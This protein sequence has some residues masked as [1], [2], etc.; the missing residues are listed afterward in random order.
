MS[1]NFDIPLNRRGTD[2]VKWDLKPKTSDGRDILPMWVADMDFAIPE[3]VSEA[4]LQRVNHPVFG[5][6]YVSDTL[7]QAFVAWQQQRN[8][9]VV[10][11]ESLVYAPGVMPAVRAA[12]L[13]I[14]E[15]GDEVI[16]QPPVYYP[17]FDAIRENGRVMVENPLVRVGDMFEMD[18]A[19]LRAQVTSRT[20][21]LLL[22]SPHNPVGRVWSRA[23]LVAL[24]EICAR[25]GITI[26]CDEIHADLIRDGYS[27][28]PL[29]SISPE[30]AGMT[31]ACSAPNATSPTPIPGPIA[32]RPIARPAASNLIVSASILFSSSYSYI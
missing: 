1:P 23:E 24:A 28:T 27:F 22:C 7:K 13:A 32:P 20:R 15:P 2:S 17:F 18:L 10:D 19:H 6:S 12:I 16:V 26:V 5:Y 4:L 3:A 30:I 29:G 11:S 8:G 21:V 14:T 25:H 9:W 31:I